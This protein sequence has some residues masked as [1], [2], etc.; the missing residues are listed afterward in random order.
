MNDNIL[1]QEI[2]AQIIH[3]KSLRRRSSEHFSLDNSEH[4]WFDRN[5]MNNQYSSSKNL[6]QTH[7]EK[8]SKKKIFA[9]YLSRRFPII[10]DLAE[11]K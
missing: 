8:I 9:G 5:E 3:K 10:F 1:Q 7:A 6:R 11:M 4:I 2:F